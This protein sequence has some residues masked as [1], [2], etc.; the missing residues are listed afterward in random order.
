M[1]G[2]GHAS[3]VSTVPGAVAATQNALGG[4]EER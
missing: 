2:D 1:S 3:E 4:Q